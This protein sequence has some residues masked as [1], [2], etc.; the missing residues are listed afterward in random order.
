MMAIGNCNRYGSTRSCTELNTEYVGIVQS[1]LSTCRVQ[2]IDPYTYLVDVL[3][4]IDTH[5]ARDVELLTPRIWKEEFGENP[6]RSDLDRV[7][8]ERSKTPTP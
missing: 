3:Q 2:G 4:R 7:K 8:L 5:P 1:L 6:L